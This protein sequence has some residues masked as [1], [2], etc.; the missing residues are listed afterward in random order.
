M[1]ML[2]M[3]KLLKKI[4]PLVL[5][6]VTKNQTSVSKNKKMSMTF[7]I[8]NQNVHTK[9]T[10]QK[11]FQTKRQRCCDPQCSSIVLVETDS[12]SSDNNDHI[13]TIGSTVT[14]NV[15]KNSSVKKCNSS[16]TICSCV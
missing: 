14:I 13:F 1:D 5:P 9:Q 2:K 15:A 4:Y 10:N 8:S 11:S 16:K 6:G 3:R 7:K 12:S